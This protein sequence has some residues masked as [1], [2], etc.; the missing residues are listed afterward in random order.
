VASSD[1]SVHRPRG[2]GRL[3]GGQADAPGRPLRAQ[4]GDAA[5]GSAVRVGPAPLGIRRRRRPDPSVVLWWS[6]G[7][8]LGRRRKAARR[9]VVGRLGVR[10][11]RRGDHLRGPRRDHGRRTVDVRLL[12]VRSAHRSAPAHRDRH[13]EGQR[14][15]RGRLG[16]GARRPALLADAVRPVRDRRR[17]GAG[18]ET[19]VSAHERPLVASGTPSTPRGTSSRRVAGRARCHASAAP[20]SERVNGPLGVARGAPPACPRGR[21]SGGDPTVLRRAGK[22]GGARRRC[23][24]QAVRTAGAR[25]PPQLRGHSRRLH[26]RRALLFRQ[27]RGRDEVREGV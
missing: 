11:P 23:L 9:V 2:Q 3:A 19:E 25:V 20:V 10:V 21:R 8:Y 1:A 24:L 12:P 14:R 22:S 13:G 18:G 7:P 26:R 5:A 15:R 6:E 4:H 16:L 17:V 27:R